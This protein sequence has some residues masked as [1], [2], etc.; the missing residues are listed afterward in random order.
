VQQFAH[1]MDKTV[2]TIPEQTIRSL[3]AHPWPGNI[4]QL[5]NVIERA[6]ILSPDSVLRVALSDLQTNSA[7]VSNL[8]SA[9]Q[10]ED[11]RDIRS[12]LQQIER[13]QIL[14]ALEE[15]HWVV[16]GSNGAANR[17]GMKRSTLQARMQKLG[18][19]RSER[20]IEKIASNSF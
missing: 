2:E 11:Q 17:L 19:V 13:Q 6:V 14:A 10:S 20:Q 9:R 7:P 18:I 4:R 16:A 12:I 1:S 8:G 5:R 15:S 3:V